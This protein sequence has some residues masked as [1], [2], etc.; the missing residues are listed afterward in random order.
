MYT[1]LVL[2]IHKH[3]HNV[4]PVAP[5]IHENEVGLF[6]EYKNIQVLRVKTLPLFNVNPLKKGIANVLLPYQY[7]RAILKYYSDIKIDLIIAPT[8]TV[9]F[10]DI[11]KSLKKYFGAK[12]YLIL[13]DIFPQN[14][15]DLGLMKKKGILFS[16]FRIKEKKLYRFSDKI[17]CTSEANIE[18]IRNNN[19]IDPSKLHI[20]YNFSKQIKRTIPNP[21]LINRYGLENKFI[22][23]FG[24]NIGIPQ[25]IENIISFAKECQ[26]YPDVVFLIIG[27]GTQLISIRTLAEKKQLNNIHF[28]DFIPREEYKDILAL[29]N[30]GLISLNEKFTVPNTPY[31]LNDYM[32]AGLPILA[33]VDNATDLGQILAESGTGLAAQAGNVSDLMEKFRILYSDKDLREQMS[34]NGQ[35]YF[36]NKLT[37]EVAYNIIMKYV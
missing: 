13:R 15:V 17:G 11:F 20:L 5:A 37:T 27:K 30:I 4:F 32:D 24:G 31:K 29:G 14:A 1:D 19:N 9:M 23:I 18:F 12:T 2:E 35:V 3:G 10:G 6:K 36:D 21:E 16:F 25:K 22:I 34:K 7:K 8:P 26:K 28:L 33:S